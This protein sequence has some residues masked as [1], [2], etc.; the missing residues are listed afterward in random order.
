MLK[1]MRSGVCAVVLLWGIALAAVAADYKYVGSPGSN[2]YHYPS[3]V[4]AKRLEPAVAVRFRSAA[5]AR[6]KGYVPCKACQA[7][8]QDEGSSDPPA[9][10]SLQ[11]SWVRVIDG[12]TMVVQLG[13]RHEAVRL[14]GVY[15]FEP[16]HPLKRVEHFG[17][18]ASDFTRRMVEG[19]KV[20]LEF[21]RQPWDKYGRLLAYVYLPDG[22]L[23][24]AEIIRQGYGFACT[25][26]P[27]Q[28]LEEFRRLERE[29][30]ERR[31]GLWSRAAG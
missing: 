20:R 29:A 2:R 22:T 6:Q 19:K 16:I 23:L 26:Y 3:C 17:R 14:I 15:T 10:H 9:P 25:E 18:E 7:P 1:I 28:H 12:D 8:A 11:G 27:F 13:G 4:W 31:R 24:N 5:E 30:R 21:D